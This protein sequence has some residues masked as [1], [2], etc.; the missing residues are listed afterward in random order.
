M[1]MATEKHHIVKGAENP[2]QPA[3]GIQS[4]RIKTLARRTS[5][6]P[7]AF[8]AGAFISSGFVHCTHLPI[9][10]T[11]TFP[12]SLLSVIWGRINTTLE[13]GGAMKSSIYHDCFLG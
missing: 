3:A 13:R 9:E 10:I 6:I 1:L 4:H 12:K 5:E 8:H 11:L 7:Q 2:W